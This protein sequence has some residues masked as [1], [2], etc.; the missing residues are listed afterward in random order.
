[1]IEL[2][3]ALS[4][5]NRLR[6]LA[7]L[8]ESEMCVCEIEACL[9]MTQ[10]N[11]SRHLTVLK[12]CGII[13]GYKKA[14]WAYYQI[15]QSFKEKN[16]GLWEYLKINLREQPTYMKDHDEWEKCKTKDMCTSVNKPL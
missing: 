5:E 15:N 13:E 11:A 2:F 1:M 8:M 6:I 4:E 7:L 12:N 16:I 3:K 14:Q 10:S 9:N